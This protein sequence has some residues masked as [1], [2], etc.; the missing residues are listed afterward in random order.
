[1]TC[2][3]IIIPNAVK[4]ND[5]FN[6]RRKYEAV[7]RRA[8]CSDIARGRSQSIVEVAKRHGVSEPPFIVGVR[9]LAI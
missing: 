1:M 5:S 2:P 7:F 6:Q 3:E 9:S 8:D 4:D